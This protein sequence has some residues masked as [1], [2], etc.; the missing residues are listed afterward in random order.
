MIAWGSYIFDHGSHSLRFSVR[1]Q[2]VKLWLD[3]K[4]DWRGIEI[5]TTRIHDKAWIGFG[6]IIL[7]GVSVGEGA[8]VGAGSVVTKDIPPWTVVAGNPARIIRE[9]N[10]YER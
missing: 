10:E 9:L 6:T 7:P 8:I 4:K 1:S 2:D 5:S 3:G